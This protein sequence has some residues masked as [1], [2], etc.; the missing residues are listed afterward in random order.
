MSAGN[1]ALRTHTSRH[2]LHVVPASRTRC[3]APAAG[4][5][6]GADIGT[7]VTTRHQRTA[8]SHNPTRGPALPG[9]GTARRSPGHP[10]L[11]RSAQDRARHRQ[12]VPNPRQPFQQPSSPSVPACTAAP[13]SPIAHSGTSVPSNREGAA[14]VPPCDRKETWPLAS[15]GNS[16]SSRRFA[17]GYRWQA[18]SRR[19]RVGP[20]TTSSTFTADERK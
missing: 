15:P 6:A 2:K 12:P 20:W 7:D 19:P 3:E 13:I 1:P 4:Q 16:Y 8:A 14:S 11:A 17:S 10:R 5:T 9:P 18:C